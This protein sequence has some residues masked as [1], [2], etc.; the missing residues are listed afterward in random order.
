MKILLPNPASG[1]EDFWEKTWPAFL[2]VPPLAPFSDVTLRFLD[3]FSKRILLDPTLRAEPAFAALAHWARRG[4]MSGYASAFGSAPAAVR[5][6][7]GMILHLAPANV[8]TLFAYSWFTAL[9][10]GNL[11]VIRVSA[12]SLPVIEPLLETLRGLLAEPDFEPLRRRTLLVSYEHDDA[13]T[14][15]FSNGCHGRLIWGGD[16]TVR[17]IRALPLP[18]TAVEIAFA[19]R[20]SL[21]AFA[22]AHVCSLDG[23]GLA[24]LAE[25]F[26]NDCFQFGQKACASPR[27]VA[28]IG[29]TAVCRQASGRLWPA[30]AAVAIRKNLL[31][32]EADGIARLAGAM[33][34]AAML[35][36][37]KVTAHP[38]SGAP[39]L[40]LHTSTWP[41]ALRNLHDG[42]GVVVE[43]DLP[44]LPDLAPRLGA[45]DQT[46]VAAG[47]GADEL[48]D[49][50]A[51]LPARALDRMVAPGHALD[52][53]P[54]A[55]DGQNL[56]EILTRLIAQPSP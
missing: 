30:V 5:S 50:A 17:A 13:V 36:D 16:E 4:H 23:A 51:G 54:L 31:T 45:R 21:G 49:F 29:E 18:A 39:P 3:G 53:D 2:A 41:T 15:R 37:A 44:A 25:A 48:R 27:L 55:W 43:L 14:T 10:S 28:F 24:R 40:V 11:N 38:A 42:A 19:D 26:A 56:L 9:L 6:A 1:D 46:L 47:F 32:G 7:R 22:A 52:F 12:R 33:A 20:F 34:L 35:D 8:D